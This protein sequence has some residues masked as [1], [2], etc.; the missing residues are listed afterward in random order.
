MKLS[1]V[2]AKKILQKKYPGKE[3]GNKYDLINGKYYSF[4]RLEDASG[5]KYGLPDNF[6]QGC[7]VDSETGKVE[8]CSFTEMLDMLIERNTTSLDW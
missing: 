2:Q 3:V 7:I 6:A 8:E 1:P 4:I 5:V